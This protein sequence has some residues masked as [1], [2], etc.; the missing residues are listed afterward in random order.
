MKLWVFGSKND[1]SFSWFSIVRLFWKS[2]KWKVLK[3]VSNFGKFRFS[4]VCFS[5]LTWNPCCLKWVVNSVFSSCFLFCSDSF[6]VS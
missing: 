5:V 1:F 2:K 4:V 3:I 6:L